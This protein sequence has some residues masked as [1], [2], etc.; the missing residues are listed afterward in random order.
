MY[1]TT[2]GNT[3]GTEEK[4]SLENELEIDGTFLFVSLSSPYIVCFSVLSCVC[5]S[6]YSLQVF[7]VLQ[8]GYREAFSI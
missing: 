6:K 1:A 7:V 8:V 4:E 5:A 3:L 2:V